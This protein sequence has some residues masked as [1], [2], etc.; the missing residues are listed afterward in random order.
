MFQQIVWHGSI[1]KTKN[2]QHANDKQIDPRSSP[3]PPIPPTTPAAHRLLPKIELCH[4]IWLMVPRGDQG[5]VVSSRRGTAT[6]QAD[7]P[8]VECPSQGNSPLMFAYE[9]IVCNK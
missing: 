4:L 5:R 2:F 9:L 3:H 6:N 7:T 1:C 8:V